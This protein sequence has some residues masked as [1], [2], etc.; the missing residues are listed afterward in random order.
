MCRLHAICSLVVTGCHNCP[1][2][3]WDSNS[4]AYCRVSE[5]NSEVAKYAV[6]HC[7]PDASICK[8]SERFV[9]VIEWQPRYAWNTKEGAENST[10]PTKDRH[11]CPKCGS[12]NFSCIDFTVDWNSCSE[13]NHKWRV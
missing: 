8:I 10:Q 4:S 9:N 6:E 12:V 5:N 1:Y 7:A 3:I 13:C 2:C 11:A